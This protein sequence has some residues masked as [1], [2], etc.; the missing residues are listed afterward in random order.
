MSDDRVIRVQALARVEGE[1]GLHI[2][3]RGNQAPEVRLE[4]YEPPRLFEALLRGRPLEDAADINARICGI[5]PVAYQMSTVHALEA[6][7]DVRCGELIRRLRRLLYCGEWIESHTLHVHLLHAPDFLGCD[8]LADL[9]VEHRQAVERGLRLK[10]HGNQLL[11]ALGGRAI[12]PVNVAVGGFYRLPAREAL[13]ALVPS[14]EWGL[15]AAVEAARWVAGFDFP[16]FQADWD[17]VA[18]VHPDEYAMNEGRIASTDGWSCAPCNFE[19]AV[20]E[21]QVP[22][23]T[24]LHARR[25][26]TGRPYLCGAVSRLNH[27]RRLLS[28]T[29]QRLADELRWETPCANPYRSIVARAIEVVHAYEEALE[30]LR[31]YRPSGVARVAYESRAGRGAAATE[32]P[33]GLLYHRYDITADGVL[34]AARIIPPTSQ[35]QAQIEA[36]LAQF[37]G[38]LPASPEPEWPRLCENLVRSYDPCISCATHFLRVAV[39]REGS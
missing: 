18:L 4:I 32:A 19:Q 2:R 20:T 3:L 23:S 9:A 16:D 27:S 30:I 36:D 6:A 33:R 13:A 28:P 24:A 37:A 7:L 12:H 8:G 15:Q 11:A 29:A 31:D 34:T 38:A 22:H 5:C 26:D 17:C 25:N 21:T 35:N 1:G 14:F 39:E 10:K